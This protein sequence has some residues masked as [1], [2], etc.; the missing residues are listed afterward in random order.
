[1]VDGDPDSFRMWCWVEI[2]WEWMRAPGMMY[3][4]RA[5]PS[6][7]IPV[8][9]S[10]I[11]AEEGGEVE[12]EVGETNTEGRIG[13]SK[14]STHSLTFSVLG[15]PGDLEGDLIPGEGMACGI[16]VDGVM[17]SIWACLEIEDE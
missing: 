10:L 8:S 17:G 6:N 16:T 13:P 5:G 9:V 7:M 1:M 14:M 15:V 3:R 4:G 11:G 2:F 12:V